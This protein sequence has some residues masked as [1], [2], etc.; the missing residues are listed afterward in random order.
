V[1][2]T[3][4][5][6]RQFR[7]RDEVPAKVLADQFDYQG[8]DVYDGFFKYKGFWYHL[9]QFMRCS[10]DPWNASLA[11]SAFTGVVIQVD[12]AEQYRVG[13]WRS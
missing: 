12:D 10:M 1:I 5:H 11:D 8:P 13:S 2:T 3:N 4:G 9:D 7:T 6:W